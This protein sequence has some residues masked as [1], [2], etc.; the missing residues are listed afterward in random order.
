MANKIVAKFFKF[1]K[2]PN[3]T[4]RPAEQPSTMLERSVEIIE[5]FDLLNPTIKVVDCFTD[6]T[7]DTWT[8]FMQFNYVKLGDTVGNG[9]EVDR[10][11]WIKNWRRE[12][13]V[14]FADC[15]VDV[16]ASWRGT[17]HGYEGHPNMQLVERCSATHNDYEDAMRFTTS[18]VTTGKISGGNP[19]TGSWNWDNRYYYASIHPSIVGKS[20]GSINPAPTLFRMT[21]NGFNDFQQFMS[22]SLKQRT[23][24]MLG[25]NKEVSTSRSVRDFVDNVICLPYK[26]NSSATEV[27]NMTFGR[28][29]PEEGGRCTIPFSGTE[30]TTFTGVYALTNSGVQLDSIGVAE[31]N[32]NIA[33]VWSSESWLNT[34]KYLSLSLNMS[35]FG[36]IPLPVDL[37]KEKS[38][39]SLKVIGDLLGNITLILATSNNSIILGRTNIAFQPNLFSAPIATSY[40]IKHA[41]NASRMSG[42]TNVLN[43]Y[44]NTVGGIMSRNPVMMAAGIT[45][46]GM[47][48]TQQSYNEANAIASVL[49][50]SGVSSVA[51]GGINLY[52][53][54]PIINYTRFAVA[55][56][57]N[58]KYGR[59]LHEVRALSTLVADGNQSGFVQ[60][61]DANIDN[62]VE[63]YTTYGRNGSASMTITEKLAICNYLN[64]GVYLE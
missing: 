37:L 56:A 43:G 39:I 21:P 61:S 64:G 44:L 52:L 1:A 41:I 17:I 24:D 3:S 34:S 60:C 11:Y 14:C 9:R 20:S 16:L 13:G 31:W 19:S 23:T 55:P 48:V 36:N 2:K 54:N 33:S 22:V 28:N 12:G 42:A 18:A 6:T 25:N 57:Q 10:Y 7:K 38:S 58:D 8:Y 15:E 63:D 49:Y 59:P 4:R 47:T 32:I 40:D 45:Q 50:P 35:P 62:V 29:D 51:A 53:S 30:A 27:Q 5:P 26:D 46:I